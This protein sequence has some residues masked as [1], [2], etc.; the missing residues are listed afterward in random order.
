[1]KPRTAL[2]WAFSALRLRQRRARLAHGHVLHAAATCIARLRLACDRLCFMLMPG[3]VGLWAYGTRNRNL[4]CVGLPVSSALRQRHARPAHGHVLHAA[5]AC[6]AP[7]C[8]GPATGCALYRCL[9]WLTHGH[10]AHEAANC[11]WPATGFALWQHRARLACGHKAK[12]RPAPGRAGT[13]GG[14]CMRV[15]R[16]ILRHVRDSAGALCYNCAHMCTEDERYEI[17]QP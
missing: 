16:S 4:R 2:R 5:A 14:P 10:A 13:R 8:A 12:P 6:I 15:E 7:G 1:M 17:W 3:A 9:A 11:A